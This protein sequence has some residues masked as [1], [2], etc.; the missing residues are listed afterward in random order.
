MAVRADDIPVPEGNLVHL[1]RFGMA[2]DVRQFGASARRL[3]RRLKRSGSDLGDQLLEIVSEGSQQAS[4]MRRAPPDMSAP[5][6]ERTDLLIETLNLESPAPHLPPE[7]R[8]RL[9]RL[10]LEQRQRRKLE[11][12]GLAPI[13]TGLFVGPPGVGKTMTAHWIASALGR[14]LYTLNL[15]ATAS[16]LFGRTGAN[17]RE[18][19]EAAQAKPSVL[20]LDEFDA[21]AKGRSEDDIGE[22][23][24]IVTVLLQLIDRWP[25]HSVLLA[26]TNHGELLDRAV[27]RRFDLRIDFPYGSFETARATALKAFGEGADEELAT[28]AAELMDGRPLADV[29]SAVTDA[30]KRALLCSEP[31]DQALLDAIAES[32]GPRS[33]KDAQRIALQLLEKGHSQRRVSEWTGVSRDTLRKK[34]KNNDG[35]PAQVSDR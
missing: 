17:L 20:L 26:A 6:G 1:V 28:L 34:T 9:D 8:G 27:W 11:K 32:G 4:S 23:K 15:A 13:R 2:G 19:L 30:R 25:A 16:S 18:A 5:V 7:L 14:P 31:L 35:G 3:A 22:A 33:R 10:I 21:I 12:A 24:R 29:W